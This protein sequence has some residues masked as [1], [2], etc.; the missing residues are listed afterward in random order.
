MYGIL[1]PWMLDDAWTPSVTAIYAVWFV[2]LALWISY[3]GLF[4]V[5]LISWVDKL[6][7]KA[8]VEPRFRPCAVA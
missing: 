2:I 1:E 8:T 5:C 4:V 6:I 3:T 7:L